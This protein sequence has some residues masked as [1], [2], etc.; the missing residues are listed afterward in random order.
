MNYLK[1]LPLI[2]IITLT[3]CSKKDVVKHYKYFSTV[4]SPSLFGAVS[5]KDGK[6]IDI[7]AI[8]DSIAYCEAYRNYCI[9]KKFYADYSDG[10]NTYVGTPIAFK[11]IN[12]T[13]IDIANSVDF[14]GKSIIELKI[15]EETSK[16][17]NLYK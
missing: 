16:L 2:F 5:Y 8:N 15:E 17:K 13:G 3:S 12:D 7:S 10:L 9:E 11:L 4:E 14:I 6:G 1:L